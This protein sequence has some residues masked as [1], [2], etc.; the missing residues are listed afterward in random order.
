ME[1]Q[2]QGLNRKFRARIGQGTVALT[3]A[4]GGLVS[5][6]FP[7]QVGNAHRADIRSSRQA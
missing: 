2:L 5:G 3:Q 6:K 7:K 4:N 1:E